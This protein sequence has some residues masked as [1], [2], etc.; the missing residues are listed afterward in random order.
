MRGNLG[1][2]SGD[3]CECGRG[4]KEAPGHEH[5]TPALSHQ[6]RLLGWMR[7]APRRLDHQS[8]QGVLPSSTPL[9]IRT[10]F[11]HR[12]ALR[13]ARQRICN[14]LGAGLRGAAHVPR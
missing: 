13:E 2:Q 8:L 10:I 7:L 14:V 12:E 4:Q 9:Q 3:H 6:A 11:S 5:D 1:L